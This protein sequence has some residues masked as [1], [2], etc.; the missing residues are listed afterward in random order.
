MVQSNK[1]HVLTYGDAFVDYIADNTTNSSFSMFL[2][3]A[4]VNVAVG[5]ARLGVPSA[6]ITIT[7][8]DTTSEFVRGELK[9]EDVIMDYAKLEPEKRVSGVYVHLT[10][11]HDRIFHRYIDDAPDIQVAVHDL[12]EEAFQKASILNLCSGTMFQPTALET[13]RKAVE[14]AKKHNALFSFDTNIRPL[15]WKS[16]AECRETISSFFKDADLLKFT[17]E[18]LTFLTETQSVE[19]GLAKIAHLDVPV[20]LITAGA[21]GTYAVLNKQLQHV[22]VEPVVAV[23]TTGAGDAFMAGVLR[24]VHLN[25]LPTTMESLVRCTAFANHLG[26]LAATKAGALTALPRLS[27]LKV[28]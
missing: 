1:T 15:R 21:D 20:I 28:T 10:E 8:D 9:K 22:P 23:D 7:G 24:Y 14:Y 6:F 17:E 2:G 25:G 4:T 19:E 5:V 16:E 13:S 27:E 3:G 26:A 11:D 18:E 12:K